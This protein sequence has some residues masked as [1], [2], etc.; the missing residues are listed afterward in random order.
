MKLNKKNLEYW[1]SIASNA[2]QV[3]LLVLAIFGYFY[4]VVPVYQKELLSEKI[5]QQELILNKLYKSNEEQQKNILIKENEL[6]KLKNQIKKANQEIIEKTKKLNIINGKVNLIS[7]KMYAEALY[8]ALI[9]RNNS[10]EE[11]KRDFF[12]DSKT[13]YIEK[14]LSEFII[15]AYQLLK[16]I[17][18]NPWNTYGDGSQASPQ[19]VKSVM[20]DLSKKIE[21]EKNKLNTSLANQKNLLYKIE[22]KKLKEKEFEKF[23]KEYYYHNSLSKREQLLYIINCINLEETSKAVQVIKELSDSYGNIE[24]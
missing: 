14:N 17:V 1:F 22:R 6:E 20:N 16:N 21:K 7:K 2:S 15:T 10:V 9:N 23:N 8:I 5:S 18:N 24:K 4:T 3:L 12:Y 13:E 19:I 11:Q